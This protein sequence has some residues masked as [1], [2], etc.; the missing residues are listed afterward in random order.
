MP[1]EILFFIA[2]L[3]PEDVMAEVTTFKENMRDNYGSKTALKVM[4]HITLKAPFKVPAEEH[5]QIVDWFR[6]IPANTEP[7]PITLENFGSFDNKHNKVIYVNP[8]VTEQ[9]AG[10]QKNIIN[11]FAKNFPKINMST[12]EHEFKPHMTIAYRD[13]TDE[14]YQIAWGIYKDKHYS[15]TFMCNSFCLLQHNGLRWEV[16]QEHHLP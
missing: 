13:L 14:N 3:P 10:L 11:S 5:E 9:M 8:L 15:A 7:F 12:Y 2:I 6:N 1:K 16:I 4:P